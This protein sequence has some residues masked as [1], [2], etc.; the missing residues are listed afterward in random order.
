[1][2]SKPSLITLIFLL[3]YS[4]AR[5]SNICATDVMFSDKSVCFGECLGRRTIETFLSVYNEKHSSKHVD[6]E[7][8]MCATQIIRFQCCIDKVL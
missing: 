8:A 6:F 1:M 7:K 3:F 5:V 2:S 4:L